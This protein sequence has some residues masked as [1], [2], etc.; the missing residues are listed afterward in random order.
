MTA[1]C[2]GHSWLLAIIFIAI[3][4]LAFIAVIH[5]AIR[6]HFGFDSIAIVALGVLMIWVGIHGL[7]GCYT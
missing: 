2:I 1:V 5:V 3:G 7:H 6:Y 4:I